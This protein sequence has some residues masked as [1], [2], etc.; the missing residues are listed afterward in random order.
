MQ[1]FQTTLH[2]SFMPLVSHR[3][4]K[5][6]GHRFPGNPAIFPSLEETRSFPSPPGDGFDFII[7]EFS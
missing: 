5:K 3:Q 1:E 6:P 2:P 4:I 7:E